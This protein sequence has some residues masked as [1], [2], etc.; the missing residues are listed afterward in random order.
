MLF[1]L[2]QLGLIAR[3]LNVQSM[4]DSLPEKVGA[5]H[6]GEAGGGSQIAV[7]L[8]DEVGKVGL[9]EATKSVAVGLMGAGRKFGGRFFR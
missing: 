7:G 8:L 9:L 3:F 4:A 2:Q 6:S 1:K 5:I